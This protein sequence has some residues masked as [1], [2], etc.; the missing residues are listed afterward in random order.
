M[1][2]FKYLFFI[3]VAILLLSTT[4]CTFK[5]DLRNPWESKII[6]NCVSGG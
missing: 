3:L 6:G 1:D 5:A 4:A 2:F